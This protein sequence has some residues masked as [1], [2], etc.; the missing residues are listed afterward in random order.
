MNRSLLLLVASSL[1][2]VPAL[3]CHSPVKPTKTTTTQQPAQTPAQAARAQQATDTAEINE[4]PPPA[5][6]R[7]MAIR[8]RA[9]WQNPFLI[10]SEHSVTLCVTDFSQSA[11]GRQRSTT[12]PL[13]S[14][15]AALAAIS[16]DSWPYGRV[17]AYEE[18][19]AEIRIRHKRIQV[20][21]NIE[22][23]LNVLNNLGVVAYEW[24]GPR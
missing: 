23:T 14:L 24:P 18:N 22:S 13:S 16:E 9:R 4:I 5:K 8:S 17:I 19:P 3:G 11:K 15:P 21:R 10:V 2:V 1:L 6:S 20:R 7:Y 12:M